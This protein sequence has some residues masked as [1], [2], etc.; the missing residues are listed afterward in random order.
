MDKLVD[1]AWHGIK[2]LIEIQRD[3]LSTLLAG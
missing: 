1:L 3:A 2:Q